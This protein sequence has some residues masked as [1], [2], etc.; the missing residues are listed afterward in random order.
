M[1]A[2]FRQDSYKRIESILEKA[3]APGVHRAHFLYDLFWSQAGARIN[4]MNHLGWDIQSVPLP[5]SEWVRG[6]KTK[7]VLRSKPLEAPPGLDRYEVLKG[8][9]RGSEDN[10]ASPGPL[11]GGCPVIDLRIY[12]ESLDGGGIPR[13]DR[14]TI[15][16]GQLTVIRTRAEQ[17]IPV[18]VE[19]I[20]R[21]ERLARELEAEELAV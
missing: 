20:G 9:P 10:S 8:K 19:A 13:R 4:E 18:S 3:G 5:K 7:Y 17:G 1:A 16:R 2:E 11:F 6:I 15:L 21:A 14:H 12:V